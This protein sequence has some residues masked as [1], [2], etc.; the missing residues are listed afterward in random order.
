MLQTVHL[1]L[2]PTLPDI[3]GHGNCMQTAR[4]NAAADALTLLHLQSTTVNE[5]QKLMD[6]SPS[7]LSSDEIINS[8][9][10]TI[11]LVHEISLQ[12]RM[13]V[14]FEVKRQKLY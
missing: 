11:S 7:S 6:E 3:I 12:R 9:K 8:N 2:D 4:H 14:K 1:S 5:K 10:S 13:D